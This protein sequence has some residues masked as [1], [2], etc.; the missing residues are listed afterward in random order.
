MRKE[1]GRPVDNAGKSVPGKCKSSKADFCLD[2]SRT[3][4]ETSVVP[5]EW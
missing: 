1:Q 5:V 3:S 4:K 2:N